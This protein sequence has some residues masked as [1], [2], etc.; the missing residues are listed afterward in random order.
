MSSHFIFKCDRL[1]DILSTPDCLS[2]SIFIFGIRDIKIGCRF[3]TKVSEHAEIIG[4]LG[5]RGLRVDVG[6]S[7][8]VLLLRDSLLYS[9][10][11]KSMHSFF[12]LF[13]CSIYTVFYFRIVCEIYS[14]F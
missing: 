3:F 7:I 9:F 5:L 10:Y 2:S 8:I 13:T 6:K 14:F 11:D 4:L 1:L 12:S